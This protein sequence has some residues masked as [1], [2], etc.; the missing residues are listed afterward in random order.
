MQP[1]AAAA[2]ARFLV[3][4]HY[5]QQRAV[6]SR[7]VPPAAAL[8]AVRVFAHK[9]HLLAPPRARRAAIKALRCASPIVPAAAAAAAAVLLAPRRRAAPLA[10]RAVLDRGLAL[11]VPHEA[12]GSRR[13]AA[14]QAAIVAILPLRVADALDFDELIL[15]LG[16]VRHLHLALPDVALAPAQLARLVQLPS[17][18]R[19]LA[20]H[21]AELVA[22]AD[23][24][25][26]S[27][28]DGGAAH[29]LR[30][31]PAQQTAALGRVQLTLTAQLYPL[32]G[33]AYV[34]GACCQGQL[35][36]R[37]MSAEDELRRKR[38]RAAMQ[39]SITDLW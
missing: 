25:V 9:L 35:A 19:F 33:R 16:V 13:R 2:P 36:A 23:L 39:G 12:D 38:S 27:E 21:N 28:G 14:V 7:C 18:Q 34:G 5:L 15:D 20:A 1:S 6:E 32:G 31:G 37:S 29:H 4:L 22:V 30:A 26:S 24:L 11:R 17:A 3:A 10:V 8:F